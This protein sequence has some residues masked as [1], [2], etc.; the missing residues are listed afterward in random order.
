[1]KGKERIFALQFVAVHVGVR[2]YGDIGQSNSRHHFTHISPH[3]GPTEHTHTAEPTASMASKGENDTTDSTALPPTFQDYDRI[4]AC[5]AEDSIEALQL[6]FVSQLEDSNRSDIR[7]RLFLRKLACR[8]AKLGNTDLVLYLCR[9]K[10]VSVFAVPLD[11]WAVLGSKAADDEGP[12]G[13][14]T[15]SHAILGEHEELALALIGLPGQELDCPA[16]KTSALHLAAGRG[17]LR[18][19]KQLILRHGFNI[20]PLNVHDITPICM[21]L[22]YGQLPV[23]EFLLKQY[24]AR[25][26]IEDVLNGACKGGDMP[27]LHYC[28]EG[29]GGD[30]DEFVLVDVARALIRDWGADLWGVSTTPFASS[31]LHQ[32]AFQHNIELVDFFVR[33]C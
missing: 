22:A 7:V 31:A 3:S 12:E 19:A 29:D 26:K 24:R 9:N 2:M 13:I 14:S 33:E 18:L 30:I 10:Y 4:L 28:C 8:A 6:H 32:A 11:E 21:A 25:G 5:L 23:V 17:M 1:M 27:L 16:H 15:L 20:D